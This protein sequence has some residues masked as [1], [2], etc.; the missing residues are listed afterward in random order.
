MSCDF[1]LR[2]QTCVTKQLTLFTMQSNRPVRLQLVQPDS[3][4]HKSQGVD[5][6]EIVIK[7][8]STLLAIAGVIFGVYKFNSE[9]RQNE[10]HVFKVR[11]WERKLDTYSLLSRV[12]GD[13][14]VVGKNHALFDSLVFEYSKLYFSSLPLV[15]DSLVEEKLIDFDLALTDYKNDIKDLAYLKKKQYRLMQRLGISI[16]Q[17]NEIIE[18]Q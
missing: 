11:L 5:Y 4:S 7:M 2:E 12:T 1:E 14:I 15:Q 8:M 10:T 9:Q 17:L 3:K 18:Q 16:Q 6:V 13:I